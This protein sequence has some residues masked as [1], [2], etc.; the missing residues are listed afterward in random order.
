MSLSDEERRIVVSL[1]YEKPMIEP[2][3]QLIGDIG[4]YIQS[5]K[6]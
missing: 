6:A 2:T 4:K 5:T 1:E 3:R